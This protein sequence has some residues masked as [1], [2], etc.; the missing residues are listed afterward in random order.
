MAQFFKILKADKLGEPWESHGKT[1]QTWWCQLEGA[2]KDVSI[3]KQV[4]NELTPGMNIYGDLMI[5]TSQKGTSY[6]KFKSAQ[7]PEGVQRPADTPNQPV[8][9]SSGAQPEW[10][11]MYANMIT[12]IYKMVKD[13]HGGLE[14]GAAVKEVPE[15]EQEE[16]P[17]DVQAQLDD[18]FGDTTEVK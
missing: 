2:D 9:M 6:Y 3:G 5:A 8:N 12:D 18:I 17:D 16:T 13:L 11:Q 10:F 15:V 7:I 4:G 1:N 14:K